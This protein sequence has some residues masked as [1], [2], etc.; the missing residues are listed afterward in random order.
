ML[1]LLD[2]DI[3]SYIIKSAS[4]E[5]E[6]KLSS[7]PV[8]QLAISTISRAELLYGLRRKPTS[9]RLQAKV[10]SFLAYVR[11]RSWDVGAADQYAEI[12][13]RLASTRQS[14]GELDAMIAAHAIAL[15]ATLVSNN[16]RHY[17][18]VGPPLLLENWVA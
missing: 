16:T 5:L 10:Q 12:R 15:G 4:L 6:C 13:H 3:A 18:R 11:V 1:Y 2:T 9:H 8:S 17:E 14:I 7:I